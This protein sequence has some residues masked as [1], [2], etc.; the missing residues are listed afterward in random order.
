[1]GPTQAELCR[2][3]LAS[4][5]AAGP[6]RSLPEPP[7][8]LHRLWYL[9]DYHSSSG[10]GTTPLAQA[11]LAFKYRD[12]RWTGRRLGALMA[13]QAAGLPRCFDVVVPV[14]L[15]KDRLIERGYDQ[16]AW[17]ALAVAHRLGLPCPRGALRRDRAT[18]PQA[19]LGKTRR[20]QNPAGAFSLTRTLPAHS[21]V[22]LV[23]D[24]MT[25]GATLAAASRALAAGG[26]E[27][28]TALVLLRTGAPGPH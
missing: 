10:P 14:P 8:P 2:A 15:H 16:A 18:L 21:R 23:D 11:L 1:M 12:Q 19:G 26:L 25:T 4:S 9:A 17:L 28:I 27:R 5:G 6:P 20:Q 7:D 24:V 13:R 22:L 3:C